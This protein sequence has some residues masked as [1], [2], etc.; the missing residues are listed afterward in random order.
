MMQKDLPIT[1][2]KTGLGTELINDVMQMGKDSFWIATNDHVMNCLVRGKIKKLVTADGYCPVVNQLHRNKQGKLFAAT[3][4]GIFMYEHDR[5]KHLSFNNKNGENVGSYILHIQALNDELMLVRC[6]IGGSN[7]TPA[8][9]LYNYNLQKIISS[10]GDAD[11]CTGASK[12]V[13]GL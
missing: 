12:A 8:T 6:D 3:D 10:I 1:A 11:F 9:F 5:F 13:T 7:K 4:E 2:Q